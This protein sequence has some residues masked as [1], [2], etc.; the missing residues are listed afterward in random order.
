MF[1]ETEKFI[2]VNDKYI[3]GLLVMNSLFFN[4]KVNWDN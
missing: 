3:H 2:K 1:N 4:G